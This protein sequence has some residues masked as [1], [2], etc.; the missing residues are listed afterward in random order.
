M[1]KK[2]N[3]KPIGESRSQAVRGFLHLEHSLNSKNQFQDFETVMLEYFDLGHA[4]LVPKEDMHKDPSRVFYLPIHAVYQNSST[5]TKIRVVFD[6]LAKS[7]SG[8][9]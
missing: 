6:A 9:F 8:I 1:P 4:E 7:A 2:S 3:T 5:M